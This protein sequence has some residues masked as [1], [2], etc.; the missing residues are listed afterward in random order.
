MTPGVQALV[1]VLAGV[2]A[3]VGLV[4]AF[5]PRWWLLLGERWKVRN[6]SNAE[7]SDD[8]VLWNRL[9]G[10]ALLVAAGALAL[11]GIFGGS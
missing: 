7:P 8:Y 5:I 11:V 1:L 6:G 10:I 3:A 9:V 2:L 4:R